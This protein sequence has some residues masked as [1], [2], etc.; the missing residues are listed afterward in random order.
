MLTYKS[1]TELGDVVLLNIDPTTTFCTVEALN[2]PARKAF[3]LQHNSQF[4]VRPAQPPEATRRSR[5]KREGTPS[6]RYDT[7][8][9]ANPCLALTLD[10]E[11][12]SDPVKGYYL[13]SDEINEILLDSDNK[14]GVSGTHFRICF[15]WKA[16]PEPHIIVLHNLSCNGTRMQSPATNHEAIVIAANADR[17]SQMLDMTNPTMINAGPVQLSF[18]ILRHRS[19]QEESI[20]REKWTSFTKAVL[21]AQPN[22]NRIRLT[23]RWD[24]TPRNGC[25]RFSLYKDHH[26]GTGAQGTVFEARE[27]S[28]GVKYAAKMLRKTEAMSVQRELMIIKSLRHVCA[29]PLQHSCSPFTD[30]QTEE[31]GQFR[32]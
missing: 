25:Q 5:H 15:N 13:G 21:A 17:P 2:E 1:K 28:T 6:F 24:P 26:I 11:K 4:L 19:S 22:L 14:Q 10:C 3:T 9:C 23:P 16:N 29:T 20:F 7:D 8:G 27:N 30:H 12:M 18:Q 32:R 31:Y